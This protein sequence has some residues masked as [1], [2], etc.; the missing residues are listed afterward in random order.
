MVEGYYCRIMRRAVIGMTACVMMI[1]CATS[2][3][4]SNSSDAQAN[5]E[6]ENQTNSEEENQIKQIKEMLASI[7]DNFSSKQAI[8]LLQ[9][10]ESLGNDSLSQLAI[11][12]LL[13]YYEGEVEVSDTLMT[14]HCVFPIYAQKNDSLRIKAETENK[15]RAYIYNAKSLRRIKSFYIDEQADIVVP[16]KHDAVYLLDVGAGKKQYG[17][18]EMSV[19]HHD[20]NGIKNP[21]VVKTKAV[22]CSR[23]D[24]MAEKIKGVNMKNAFRDVRKFTLRSNINAFFSGSSRAVV[25]IQI[26]AGATDILYSLTISTNEAAGSDDKDEFYNEMNES[27]T[28][29]KLLGLPIYERRNSTSAGLLATM[30]G[31]NQPVRDED[32]YINMYVFFNASQ[33]RKF[34]NGASTSGLKYSL[35]YSTLGT[36]SCN[37]RIPCQG[38][39]TVYLGFQNERMR[40]N[41]YVWV[42]ALLVV[43][44][45][46][47]V[48]KDYYAV[49][50]GEN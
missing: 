35:D 48:R 32:A 30:L 13:T 43:P 41:N 28:K 7:S 6:E 10:C 16:I 1:V 44:Q 39:R 24:F 47:Y 50:M 2:C 29:V 33:A 5:S 31:M 18:V 14:G 23:N 46:E 25:P 34:Q 19:R 8:D 12:R 45:T 49:P 22:N 17:S 4:G 36:Q 9:A 21:M 37:G 42:S 26:E 15:V 20:I 3:G 27:Y 40:Y 11:S 38:K